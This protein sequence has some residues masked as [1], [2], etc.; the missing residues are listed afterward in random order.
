LTE[1]VARR[2]HHITREYIA[3][4]FETMRVAEIMARP[5]TVCRRICR[6]PM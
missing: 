3:D 1:K 4:P 6:S 2:G 5:R